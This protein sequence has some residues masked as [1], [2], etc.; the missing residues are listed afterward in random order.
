MSDEDSIVDY[1]KDKGLPSDMAARKVI[2]EKHGITGYT[3]TADQ[4]IKL[5]ALLRN[6]PLPPLTFWEQLKALFNG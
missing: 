5:L 6:P 2:A 1:L 3:G 4:N